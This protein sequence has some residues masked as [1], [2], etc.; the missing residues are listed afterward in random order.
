MNYAIKNKNF[1]DSLSL[2]ETQKKGIEQYNEKLSETFKI[3]AYYQFSYVYLVQNEDVY[4]RQLYRNLHL[5]GLL[6]QYL[7]LLN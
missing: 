5:K 2:I 7:V 6:F 1:D 3:T 4:K